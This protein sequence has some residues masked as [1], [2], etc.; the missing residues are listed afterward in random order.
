M[1]ERRKESSFIV[2]WD[3][4]FLFT[5]LIFLLCNKM[6]VEE[7][8]TRPTFESTSAAVREINVSGRNR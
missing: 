3:E 6:F 5:P 1:G 7:R 2:A 4:I 8:E